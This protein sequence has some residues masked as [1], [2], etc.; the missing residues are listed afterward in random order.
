VAARQGSHIRANQLAQPVELPV[1]QD[2]ACATAARQISLAH[3]LVLAG[4]KIRQGIQAR[5][6]I[7]K[8][9]G[10]PHLIATKQPVLARVPEDR[11]LPSR[12][13]AKLGEHLSVSTPAGRP[14][15]DVHPTLRTL[16]PQMK[17]RRM[18]RHLD[19]QQLV[20][21]VRRGVE[22]STQTKTSTAESNRP[23]ASGC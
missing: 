3:R 19:H 16:R 22:A 7:V 15:T 10:E 17:R 12:L 18:M 21:A 8:L 2:R 11:R 9:L 23:C 4:V 1:G 13:A 14:Q 5:A 20:L 6:A